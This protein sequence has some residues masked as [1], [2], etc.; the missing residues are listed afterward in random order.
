VRVLSVFLYSLHGGERPVATLIEMRRSTSISRGVVFAVFFVIVLALPAGADAAKRPPSKQAPVIVH[1][2]ILGSLTLE[3]PGKIL[4]SPPSVS[5]GAVVTFKIVNDDNDDHV[6]A[7]NGYHTK[8]IPSDGGRATLANIKFSK[9][10]D[11]IA[12]CPDVARGIGG[13]FRVF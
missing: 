1:V 11:Y 10:G 7:I 8:F 12:S 4:F 6:M 9:R 2:K 13:A 5:R 3:T